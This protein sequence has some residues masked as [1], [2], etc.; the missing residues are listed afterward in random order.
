MEFT[1]LEFGSTGDNVKILQEKLKLLN[2]YSGAIT[3]SF[4]SSTEDAVIKFQQ[5]YNLNVTGYVDLLTWNTLF[6]ATLSPFPDIF[7]ETRPTLRLGDT[8]DSVKLLQTQLKAMLYYNGNISG[9][10]D[11]TTQSAVKSFQLVNNLTADGVVGR[12]TWSALAYLYKPLANCSTN[13]PP[14]DD[15]NNEPEPTPSENTHIV[16]AGDTLY[17]IANKY[18]LTVDKLK[19]LNNL[20]SNTISIGQE[21]II[22][23]AEETPPTENYI[24]HLVV[25]GDTLWSLSR[26][27]N[28]SVD[29]IRKVNNLSSDTLSIGQ[30]L[31]IPTEEVTPIPEYDIYT[32]KSGDSLWSIS[33]VYNTTVDNLKN[34][35]NLTSNVL[36]IG[37]QLKVPKTDK[38]TYRTHTVVKGDTL[39]QIANNYGVSVDAIKNLNNLSSNTL[40]IGQIL[41]IP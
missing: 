34:I 35:N 21:L 33:R 1:I 4:G 22:K 9:T 29:A 8:G 39:W 10:F 3:G 14:L 19:Q 24:D 26:K 41:L 38:P 5:E 30:V 32:V 25:S 23:E 6:E 40:S 7:R 15:G 28:T 2:Y 20:T 31:K 16:V 27:Y 12:D 17:S 18:S 11:S 37:Q 36:S 13:I